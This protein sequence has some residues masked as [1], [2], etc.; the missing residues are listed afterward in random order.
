MDLINT[1]TNLIDNLS[2]RYRKAGI[3]IM[4]NFSF[5]RDQALDNLKKQGLPDHK[6]EEYKYFNVLRKINRDYTFTLPDN[7]QLN[8][9]WIKS[10]FINDPGGIR[11]VF[12]NGSLSKELS[13]S[14]SSTTGYEFMKLDENSNRVNKLL[15]IFLQQRQNINKDLYLELN[16]AF[17]NAGFI[18]NL[19]NQLE[20]RP[21]YIYHFITDE[22]HETFI[23]KK[24]L[25]FIDK[26]TRAD[27]VEI[28]YSATRNHYFRNQNTEIFAEDSVNLNYYLVQETGSDTV[29]INNT[30]VYQ[31][32][33]S[34]V[35]T[36]TFSL[37]GKRLRNNLNMLLNKKNCESHLFGL[38]F[39]SGDDHIDNHTTVDH[40]E[41]HCF[42]NEYYKGIIDDNGTATFNGKIYVRPNAQKT[43]AFQSNKNLVLTDSATINTKPQLEIW[44][45]DVK[46][47]HGATT[48]QI[49]EEQLFYLRSRGLDKDSA[50]AL[51][52]HAF[53]FEIVDM[54]ELSDLK[55]YIG[56]KINMRLGY[57][58]SD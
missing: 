7:S 38:Y 44:A 31:S 2:A 43:N 18:L 25:I 4:K 14:N 1:E 50:T 53:A 13:S 22:I 28:F 8:T 54:V 5:L 40:N 12:I 45:D 55:K 51:L 9:E 30:N 10:R 32:E 26:D 52:L 56:D 15:D 16:N 35:N 17:L 23:N 39:I 58:F 34:H 46:C 49:D 41:P 33:N 47:S 3:E 21:V 6:N 57:Q 29:F 20:S 24:G 19:N 36:Y 42:S 37:G 11:I 27:I 48:G